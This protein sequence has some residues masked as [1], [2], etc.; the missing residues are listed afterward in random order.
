MPRESAG[1]VVNVS[2]RGLLVQAPR[3]VPIGTHLVDNRQSPVGRVADVIGPVAAPYLVVSLAKGVPAQ[4]LLSRD[5][6]TR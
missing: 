2:A 3:M 1:K 4:R 6:Y 5:V